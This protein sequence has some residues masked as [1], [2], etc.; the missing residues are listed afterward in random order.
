MVSRIAD[1]LVICLKTSSVVSLK[2]SVGKKCHLQ[3]LV[4]NV[5]VDTAY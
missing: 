3:K 2:A 5:K 1:S 4:L